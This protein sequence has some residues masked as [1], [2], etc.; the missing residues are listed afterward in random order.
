MQPWQTLERVATP[1]GPLELRRRGARDF[2]IMIG[3]RVLMTSASHRSEDVLAQRACQNIPPG[4]EARVLVGGLGMGYT[5]RAALQALPAKA[6]VTVAELNP[7]VVEWCRGPLAVLTDQVL[8]DPRVR[9]QVADVS[10]V[11]RAAPPRHYDAIILDLYEGPHHARSREAHDLYG[12]AALGRSHR[13]LR[14]G[15]VLAVWSEE[16]DRPFEA[17]LATAGFLVER[18]RS[19]SGRVHVVYVGTRGQSGAA[20]GAG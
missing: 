13:A 5:L 10:Q 4:K 14:P 6:E 17:R 16:P 11:I 9:V 19:G 20:L 15:G 3:G 7:Q 2:L 1:E 8:A 12:A 18:V